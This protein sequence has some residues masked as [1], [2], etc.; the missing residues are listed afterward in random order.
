MSNH[1]ISMAYKRDLR[2][3]MRKSVMVLLADKA[4]DD[5]AGIYASK[6]TMA[7]ELCCSKQTV[8]DTIRGFI[9]EGLLVEI[10]H[11]RN[12]NGYTVEY[13]IVVDALKRVPLVKCHADRSEKL[14]G[15]A[16]G[17][18]KQVDAT[19]QA[20]G[21]KPSLNPLPPSDPDGSDTP[22]ADFSKGDGSNLQ[23]AQRTQA[24]GQR[25]PDGWT[26]PAVDDLPPMA[27]DLVR[28]W[29]AG[30][31]AASC[32]TF[33]LHWLSETRAIGR[34][35]DWTAAL[36]K[37][38]I[39]DHPKVMRDAKAG[40]SFAPVAARTGDAVPPPRPVAAKAGEDERSARIHAELRRRLGSVAYGRWIEP[41]A[42]IV[43]HGVRVIAPSRFAGNWISDHYSQDIAKAAI[44]VLG[45]GYAPSWGGVRVEV[46][47]ATQTGQ[48]VAEHGQGNEGKTE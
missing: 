39:G 20:A 4:S 13:G 9:D 47:R 6:T 34:K 42:L 40:V 24:K 41:C 29:P 30:A 14:T 3:A 37:W 32:E 38:L 33:R 36:G 7:D 31:Y 16:A 12:V 35:R 8:I 22:A 18:V 15:Q 17:P 44:M 2:T 46:E 27:R 10:G 21:P 43:H 26:A 5:G 28:Q 45:E 48:R 23:K 19:G 25:L 11:R 1:L